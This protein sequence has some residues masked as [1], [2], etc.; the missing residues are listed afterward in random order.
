MAAKKQQSKSKAEN[1]YRPPIEQNRIYTREEAA[2]TVGCSIITLI[3]AKDSGHLEAYQVGRR[4]LHSG[5][6]LLLWL[7]NG[8]KTSNVKGGRA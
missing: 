8:G 3:R 2:R 7:E 6:H 5:N 1:L 4:V